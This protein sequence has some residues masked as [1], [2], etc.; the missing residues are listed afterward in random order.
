MMFS[1][2]IPAHNEARYIRFAV[3][4][5]YTHATGHEFEIIV[6]DNASTDNT[7]DVVRKSY[8]DAKVIFEKRKGTGFARNAG[9]AQAKGD[10][11]IFFDSDVV[12]PASWLPT[13]IQNFSQNPS[14]VALS[15]PYYHIGLASWQ[16]FWERAYYYLGVAPH[17]WF[18]AR[19]LN[20]GGIL[21]GGNIAVKKNIFEAVGGF[22]TN[23]TF[24]GDDTMLAKRLIKKGRIDFSNKLFVYTSSRRI[25]KKGEPWHKNLWMGFWSIFGYVLNFYWIIFFNKPAFDKYKDIR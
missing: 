5:I 15:G 21:I 25:M 3:Q 13:M 4:S 8:P 1:F 20:V 12:M 22:D 2:I 19:L 16:R 23:L 9:A 18:F 6:V 14:L 24:W 7:A 17:Q 10:M 11:L